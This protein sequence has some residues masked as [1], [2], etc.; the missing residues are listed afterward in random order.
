[1]KNRKLLLLLVLPL[2]C[3]K[4]LEAQIAAAPQIF[5]P[6]SSTLLSPF[7]FLIHDASA[8]SDPCQKAYELTQLLGKVHYKPPRLNSDWSTLVF[9]RF[10]EAIDPYHLILT[11]AD[12]N[13]LRAYRE[14]ID[15]QLQ[16]RTCIL[17]D[18]TSEIY[19]NG[20][21]RA[22]QLLE[23]AS[24]KPLSWQTQD[25]LELYPTHFSDAHP[26]QRWQQWIAYRV[27]YQLFQTK[28]PP[29]A[30]DLDTWQAWQTQ[31]AQI[32]DQVQKKERCKIEKILN[33]KLGLDQYLGNRFMDVLCS[34]Y[35][36]HTAYFS[37]E[38]LQGFQDQLSPVTE[39]YGIYLDETSEGDIK[40]E[41]LIP[42]G[43]AW[44]SNE[45][46]QGD[47]LI[48][49]TEPDGQAIDLSCA[50]E[51][52]L[53]EQL[54]SS[55]HKTLNF[56]L[57]KSNGQ[58]K[59]ISLVKEKINAE[60]NLIK[61]LVL[62]GETNVGYIALPGFYTDWESSGMEGCAQDVAR[63]ILKLKRE[64][65]EGLILDLRFNGGGSMF[66]AMELA[67]IF[68]DE[69][70]LCISREQTQEEEVLKDRNRGTIFDGPLILMVNRLSA[71]A[72]E[73]LAGTLQDYHR[74]VIVGTPTFGKASGQIILP[75]S[76]ESTESDFVKVT[77]NRYYR[78]DGQSHQ[79]KGVQPDITLP[80]F[81]PD[82][83][84]GEDTYE[85]ALPWDTIETEQ[86]Y[87]PLPDLPL[88]ELGSK[89][90]NRIQSYPA[91]V[92]YEK[93]KAELEIFWSNQNETIPLH[94]KSFFQSYYQPYQKIQTTEEENEQPTRNF[95]VAN[96]RY[97]QEIIQWDDYKKEINQRLRQDV[98]RDL[99]VEEAYLI[100]L[101]LI[102]FNK[103]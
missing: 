39:S 42:G 85:Q 54:A 101:D 59:T 79:Q 8:P 20:L 84:F 83:L 53:E 30:P 90:Q 82:N 52:E 68:V 63:E 67:G 61:S 45:I 81:L 76:P 64:N 16:A 102:Q 19:S 70:A 3:A 50:D 1:M 35:D 87:D 40:I 6:N 88:S 2:C 44:K 5:V 94:P 99:Y 14:Q 27:L 56:K 21:Q 9:D 46:H 15:D 69:G 72:S 38:D 12:R 22:L 25:S 37:Y 10:L 7:D 62:Q 23:E 100:T 4:P 86:T 47:I 97:D 24:Q 75:L 13:E 92:Q 103:K 32:R 57:R 93:T 96:H 41:K 33:H 98:Q 77:T 18:K 43:A 28:Q 58:I 36:P 89:S 91:F 80:D 55:S 66:E 49:I 73:I 65:I 31:E 48:E 11:P 51:E 95:Q 29:S 74:A 26:A 60:E 17:L 78:I 71:S 34:T